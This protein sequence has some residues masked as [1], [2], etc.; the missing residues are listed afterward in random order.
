MQ[1]TLAQKKLFHEQGYIRLPGLIPPAMVRAARRAINHSLGDRGMNQSELSTLR[2]QTYCREVTNQPVIV[3]L[4]HRTPAIDA[5]E[6]LVGKGKLRPTGSGQIALRFPTL[7]DPPGKPHPHVDGMY[8]PHNGMKEGTI[9]HFTML[10]SVVLSDLPEP[11]M[12]NFTVWP[13]THRLYESYFR[14]HTPQSLLKGMPPVE[15]PP[16]TQI[17]ASAGDVVI[18]HYQLAH[19]VAPHTGPDIRYAIFFRLYHVDHDQIG[20]RCMTDIWAEWDGMRAVIPA[21][22]A[23]PVGA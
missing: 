21:A 8:T 1:L 11:D 19:S 7:A 12:G 18:T 6:S 20:W 5:A 23:A 13:G 22:A 10:V 15:M 3:D 4:Y 16:P 14:E 2:S 9:G 17:I